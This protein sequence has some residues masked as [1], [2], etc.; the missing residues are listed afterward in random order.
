MSIPFHVTKHPIGFVNGRLAL[1]DGSHGGLPVMDK[2]EPIS[3]LSP[4]WSCTSAY[5]IS[6]I[7]M[8]IECENSTDREGWWLDP[9]RNVIARAAEHLPGSFAQQIGAAAK[10]ALAELWN[11]VFTGR[12]R[13]AGSHRL[14]T[15]RLGPPLVRRQLAG[16]AERLEEPVR[17]VDLRKGGSATDDLALSAADEALVVR[18]SELTLESFARFQFRVVASGAY[19]IVCPLSAVPV[20]SNKSILLNNFQFLIQFASAAGEIYFM[21][22]SAHEMRPVGAYFPGRNLLVIRSRFFAE[23]TIVGE[24]RVHIAQMFD[25][26]FDYLGHQ[27]DNAPLVDIVRECHLAHAMYNEY[28][29]IFRTIRSGFADKVARLVVI[30]YPGS[31]LYGPLDEIFPEFAGRIVRIGSDFAAIARKCYCNHW[32]AIRLT[33][34]SVPDALARRVAN[35]VSILSHDNPTL[36]QVSTARESG[37]QVIVLGL[38][39]ENRTWV[40]LAEGYAHLV[41]SL[42]A[43]NGKFVVLIDGHNL[44]GIGADEFIRIELG[45]VEV[46]KEAAGECENVTVISVVG[47]GIDLNLALIGQADFFVAPWGAGN[48]KYKWVWNKPGIVFSNRWNLANKRDLRIWDHPAIRE[49]AIPCDFLGPQFVTDRPDVGKHENRP[50]GNPAQWSNFDLDDRELLRLFHAYIENRA[51]TAERRFPVRIRLGSPRQ[52]LSEKLTLIAA[53]LDENCGE[54][55]WA[56]TPASLWPLIDDISIYV[57]ALPVATAFLT[58]WRVG[59]LVEAAEDP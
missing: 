52:E 54:H 31:E 50:Y 43:C 5:G 15:T 39:V 2:G 4:G 41:R 45:I 11:A 22:L 49:L 29:G 14:S 53:W 24:L 1:L 51:P 58:R 9:S 12:F 19:Q 23:S 40:R 33:D 21:I 13:Q 47:M 30:K 8:V 18:V 25:E 56:M 44:L 35:R 10:P 26:L 27:T 42:A 17:L 16:L 55:G 6:D 32:F 59:R 34:F 36:R 57:G 46:L 38:R 3:E 37:S 7:A 48:A 20:T 28:A